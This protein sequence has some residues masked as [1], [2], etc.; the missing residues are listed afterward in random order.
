VSI[1]KE[2]SEKFAQQVAQFM[3]HVGVIIEDSFRDAA[4]LSQNPNKT[5]SRSSARDEE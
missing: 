4:R 5:D 2:Q 3:Q 1:S